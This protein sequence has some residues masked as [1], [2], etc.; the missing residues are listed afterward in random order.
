MHKRILIEVFIFLFIP[1]TILLSQ[2]QA[3]SSLNDST[4]TGIISKDSAAIDTTSQTGV[5]MPNIKPELNIPKLNPGKINIDGIINEEVWK[6]AAVAE[7][8]TEISPGDNV[9]PEVKTEAK[10]FYDDEN[11]YFAFICYE[12][13]MTSVRASISDRDRMYGDDWVGPFINTYGDLKQG[14]E[15][16]VNPKGIQGDLLW[17]T[18]NEDSNYD[19]I[20]ESEAKMYSD[21]W[22]AEMK[23]PFKSLRFPDKEEQIWRI[24]ILRPS[25][26]G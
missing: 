22:T 2:G 13:D 10:V 24:H 16:Y 15:T 17:T 26:R 23:I 11:I 1:F 4:S 6:D 3:D 8:F 19:I 21:K 25:P 12:K 9:M 5:F 20:F 18:N 14:F 7:N